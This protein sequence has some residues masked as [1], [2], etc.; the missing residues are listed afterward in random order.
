MPNIFRQRIVRSQQLLASTE[1]ATALILSSATVKVRSHDSHYPYRADNYLY[2]LTGSQEQDLLLVLLPGKST[3]VLMAPPHDAARAVWD[4]TAPKPRQ[5]ASALGA[6]LITTSQPIKELLPLL[7]NIDRVLHQAAP[8]SLARQLVDQL[9][10]KSLAGARGL[11]RLFGDAGLLL[12]R[13]RLFKSK[14]EVALIERAAQITQDS[15]QRTLPLMRP[16]ASEATIAKTLEYFFRLQ[17]AEPAFNSIV[18]AG[19]SAAT[20]HYTSLRR[21]IQR[22]SLLLI[23]C[24]A[25]YQLYAADMT[26]TI[27]IGAPRNPLLRKVYEGVLHAQQELLRAVRPGVA[28]ATLQQIAIRSLTATLRDL[29]VLR[30]SLA[31]LIKQ[32]AYKPYYPHSFGHSLGLDVHDVGS[33][34]RGAQT[35]LEKGM[36]FTIE[37]GLYFR[38]PNG[39]IPVGGGAHRGRRPRYLSRLSATYVG[40][41]QRL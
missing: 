27:P 23:D 25:E 40:I 14:D 18:A 15:L 22:G 31:S 16:G 7:R 36:V 32:Q 39:K 30:G 28:L 2:Y 11:P 29:K 33:S 10:E 1:T 6:R 34:K 12:D 17:G 13:L 37:P 21:S 9:R 8:Q 24:G 19:P 35:V 3:P 38:R 26:R 41:P 20:L 4:D 5:L